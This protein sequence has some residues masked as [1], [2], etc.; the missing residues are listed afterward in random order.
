MWLMTMMMMMMSVVADPIIG[1]F[2]LIMRLADVGF[3]MLEASRDGGRLG[4]FS[5]ATAGVMRGEGGQIVGQKASL[6]LEY[7]SMYT[8]L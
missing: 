3:W 5:V 6:G 1:Q 2:C 8:E 4:L 7:S